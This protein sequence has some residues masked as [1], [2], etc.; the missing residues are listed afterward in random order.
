MDPFGVGKWLKQYPNVFLNIVIQMK[1]YS[2]HWKALA[3]TCGVKNN[4]LL[5]QY[6]IFIKQQLLMTDH[7]FKKRT[8]W[9]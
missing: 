9:I 4:I 6:D 7:L 3:S 8:V 2:L 1:N 5:M